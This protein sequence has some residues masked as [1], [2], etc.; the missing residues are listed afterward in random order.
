ML[1]NGMNVA[2]SETAKR[3]G[4][5]TFR[6]VIDSW[7]CANCIFV[8]IGLLQRHFFCF[9]SVALCNGLNIAESEA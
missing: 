5:C 7:G 6:A 8:V 3:N 1:Y 4:C 2:E 9:S